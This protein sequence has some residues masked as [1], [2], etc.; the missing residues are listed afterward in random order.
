[1]NPNLEKGNNLERAVYS[2][3]KLILQ[4]NPN[5]KNKP[6][7]IENKKIFTTTQGVKHEIDVYVEIDLG[8]NYKSIYIF[9]CKNWKKSLGKNEIIIF[10]EKIEVTNATAGFFIAKDFTRYALAQAK[11]NSRI[12]LLEVSEDLV[13]LIDFPHFHYLYNEPKEVEVVFEDWETSTFQN[14]LKKT[15]VGFVYLN[16][17]KLDFQKFADN[18]VKQVIDNK[19]KTTSTASMADGEYVFQAE[20]TFYFEQNSLVINNENIKSV[21]CKVEFISRIMKPKIICKFDIEK[22]GRVIEFEPFNL[23]SNKLLNSK[24]IIL[25][26]ESNDNL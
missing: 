26:N 9:E 11:Q 6:F 2:I 8:H 19:M 10:S 24:F 21:L 4:K 5:L 22:R 25:Q 1:M 7:I 18:L 13:E 15:H 17:E 16:K 12:H 14:E 3:E 20:D 23:N